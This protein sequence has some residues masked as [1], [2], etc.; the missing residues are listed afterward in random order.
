MAQATLGNYCVEIFY[1][2][3]RVP[4]IYLL[5]ELNRG[6]Y[7]AMSTFEFERSCTSFPARARQNLEEFVQFC[8]DT[9]RKGHRL[10]DDPEVRKVLAEMAELLSQI[11]SVEA[12]AALVELQD[13]GRR[14]GNYSV[15]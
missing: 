4:N 3:V 15:G 13:T 1:N 11:E 14:K 6:F 2:N 5:G 12:A 10:F 7:H 9:K 8:K